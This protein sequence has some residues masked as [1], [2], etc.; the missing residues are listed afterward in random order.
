MAAG[1]GGQA[2]APA[3]DMVLHDGISGEDGAFA[4]TIM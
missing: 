4:I 3:N 2:F 1:N